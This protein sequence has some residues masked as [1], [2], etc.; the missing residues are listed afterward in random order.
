MNPVILAL[1]AAAEGQRPD[2]TLSE[3]ARDWLRVALGAEYDDDGSLR[4]PAWSAETTRAT[5]RRLLPYAHAAL[6]VGEDPNTLSKAERDALVA[7]ADAPLPAEVD[8]L[9]CAL[10]LAAMDEGGV[11]VSDEAMERW[12]AMSDALEGA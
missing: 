3:D 10:G 9:L 4:G 8:H 1:T 6:L 12:W 11:A 7:L 5:A 2:D